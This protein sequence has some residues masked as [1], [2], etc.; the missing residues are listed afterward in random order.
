[1]VMKHADYLDGWRG[2]S[3]IFVL[4]GH[5]IHI[6]IDTADFGV[7]MFFCL[8]GLLMSNIL[9]SERQA[10]SKFYMRRISRIAPTFVVFVIT[11][12]IIA[13]LQ[14]KAFQW[15]EFWATLLFLR[16]YFPSPG[17]WTTN[18]SIGHIW[19]LN[20]EEH[21]YIFMSMLMLL[22]FLRG[23]EG[24]VLIFFGIA[25]IVNFF[26]YA[27]LGANAPYKYWGL[28]TEV[29]GSVLL[30]S[31]G[32]HL[33]C[34][35][36]RKW[37]PPWLPII[38]FLAALGIEQWAPWWTQRLII[39]FLLAFSVNHLS[40]A[41]AWIRSLLAQKWLRQIGFWSFSIYLW[42]QPFYDA[43]F[44]FPG[45]QLSALACAMGISLISFYLIE[46]PSRTWLNNYWHSWLPVRTKTALQEVD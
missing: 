46:Q 29:A 17:I 38:A 4:N 42:Q 41:A 20:I 14:E 13:A 36:V 34:D 16:T 9:F 7:K 35:R 27:K 8:S 33:I 43:R 22:R 32:Y 2:V 18:V 23:R 30:I 3:I 1:M 15:S 37:I 28:G 26:I 39:P 24:V 44:T 19:S 45:G 25:C 10:L 21:C 31:A 6:P 12:F 5:F 11:M 40:E